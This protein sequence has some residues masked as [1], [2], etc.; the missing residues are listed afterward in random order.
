MLKPLSFINGTDD[1]DRWEPLYTYIT[2][3]VIDLQNGERIKD[4]EH[5]VFER[6]LEAVYGPDVWSEYNEL[7]D[8]E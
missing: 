6:A 5:Y 8:G 1:F 2:E 3:S 7:V 4:F